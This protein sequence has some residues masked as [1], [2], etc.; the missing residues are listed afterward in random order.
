MGNAQP[1]L[2]LEE[3]MK[4]HKKNLAKAIR[5][6]DREKRTLEN[7]EKKLIMDIK[8][9]AKAGQMQSVK[10]MAKDLVRTRK[11]QSKFLEMKAQLQGVSLQLQ[12]MKSQEAMSRAMKGVTKVMVN[13]NAKM[14]APAMNK[15]MQEFVTVSAVGCYVGPHILLLLLLCSMY[16][17]F[18]ILLEDEFRL[19]FLFH[20]CYRP[21]HS[22]SSHSSSSYFLFTFTSTFYLLLHI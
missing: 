5:E 8:K 18:L 9:Q 15:V 7:N 16:A 4:I 21:H 12:T 22:S 14:N 19:L 6:L 11:Y 17:V 1:K 20:L 3:Q 10:I 2:S 13:M